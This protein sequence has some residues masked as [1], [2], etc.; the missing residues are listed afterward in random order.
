MESN[1][2]DIPD[3]KFEYDFTIIYRGREGEDIIQIK[4]SKDEI[5]RKLRYFRTKAN[6]IKHVDE[7][8]IHD[9]FRTEIFDQFIK[10]I[11]TRKLDINDSNYEEFYEISSKYE[12]YELK[13]CIEKFI[14]KR[15]DLKKIINDLSKDKSDKKIDK[16]KER[17]ISQHLDFCLEHGDLSKLPIE[18]LNRIFNSPEKV[19]H[20]HH[21]LFN[22]IKEKIEENIQN[23]D[24]LTN[25]SI[26]IGSLDYNEMTSEEII[27]FI[28]LVSDKEKLKLFSPSNSSE[29]IK[30]LIVINKSKDDEINDIKR[31]LSIQKKIQDEMKTEISNL[32][33]KY[34]NDVEQIHKELSKYSLLEKRIN[35]IELKNENQRK[36]ISTQIVQINEKI[37]SNTKSIQNILYKVDYK[38]DELDGIISYLKKTLGEN[39]IQEGKLKLSSGHE[40]VDGSIENIIKYDKK[41][42][43]EYFQNYFS[44]GL[45]ESE[46]WIEFDFV[47]KKINLT[48]YTMRTSSC[49]V[50]DM[51]HPKTW[52]VIGSN[53]KINWDVINKQISNPALN[54]RYKQHRFECEPTQQYYRYI[55]YIQDESWMPD[56]AYNIFL[57]CFE[58]FGTISL[59]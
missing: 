32:E 4:T 41:N 30:K 38:G 23:D 46:G 14:K 13:E 28:Q 25:L 27:E 34:K 43:D 51:Y 11:E 45:K 20:N 15:P 1:F 37:E 24:V 59:L 9:N 19:L 42:I 8:Y 52:R 35:E 22:F 6:E 55:R 10:S 3:N 47:D 7:L 40:P 39:L 58:L 54:G 26:M 53:D 33:Q 44:S 49:G 17:I 21:L 18:S 5:M 56:R 16:E 2:I 31:E 36:E 48:S 29:I 12:Y 57:T 50:N